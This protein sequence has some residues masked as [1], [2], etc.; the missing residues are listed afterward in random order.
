MVAV[1]PV[2]L[3]TQTNRSKE[4]PTILGRESTFMVPDDMLDRPPSKVVT[5]KTSIVEIPVAL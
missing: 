4:L 5:R 3:V 2:V 1:D